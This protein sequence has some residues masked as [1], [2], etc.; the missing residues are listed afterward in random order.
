MISHLQCSLNPTRR[1]MLRRFALDVE[2]TSG[3]GFVLRDK[4]GHEYLDCLSQYGALPFGHNPPEIWAALAAAERDQVPA[5]V[6]PLR[7]AE[8]ERLAD[9]LAEITPG[10]LR[11]TTFTNSGAETVEAA[12]KLARMRS[13]R[14]RVLSTVNGFHGKTLGALSATGKAVY[15]NGFG[16][17]VNGFNYVPYGDLDALRSELAAGSEDIAAFIVE[18]IQGEGG[19]ICPPDGYID[20]VIALCREYGVLS[21]LDEIQ[22]GMGRTGSLFACS[23]GNETPDMLLLSKALGGG[24]IP[25]GACVVRPSAWDDRFGQLHSSTFAGN[26]LA[27]R[28][29][30][31][32]IDLLLRN[33][34]EM[35]RNVAETGAYL[36]DRLCALQAAYP[37]AIKE[38]R[39]RGYMLGLEFHRHDMRSESALMAFAS[40]NGG[41]TPLI[42]SYLLNQHKVLTAPLFNDT[43]V[44]RLQPPLVIS[45]TEVDRVIDALESLC[46]ALSSHDVYQLVRHLVAKP[47]A[48]N[49]HPLSQG[50]ALVSS[51]GTGPSESAKFAFLIHYTE[52]EDICR[53]DPSFE[54]FTDAELANWR[55]W[56]KQFGPGFARAI[57]RVRSKAG[58]SAEGWIVSVPMLPEDMQG[59][60]RKLASQM[61][62]DGVDLA[63]ANG[64]TRV[65]LG[66]F[67]SIVTRGGDMVTERGVPI[68]SG[69]TLTTISAVQGIEAMA[70]KSGIDIGSAH[71]VVVGASGAIGR[72]ASLM[73]ARQAGRLTLVGNP[74]NPFSPRLLSRVADEVC[75]TLSSHSG[76]VFARRGALQQRISSTARQL[77]LGSGDLKGLAERVRAVWR[78]Q[79][80][81]CPLEWNVPVEDALVDADIILVATSSVLSLVDPA[82]LRTGT[83]VCDVAK[84]RNVADNDTDGVLVFDGGLIKP[85]FE[86]DLGPFQTL[87]PNL[88]WGCLG[89]TM[90]LALAGEE[91][92]YS[93][94]SQ[95]SL[96]DADHLARLAALHGFE[97]APAQWCGKMLAEEKVLNFAAHVAEKNSVAS[98]KPMITMLH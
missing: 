97:P 80:I 60:G 75:E 22:T 14:S 4:E 92:D 49:I 20:G 1:E 89:E 11:I 37:T 65:G 50:P 13:G 79:G 61:V 7:S 18:P 12:I 16:A 36:R 3:T 76:N 9:R 41:I 72:L 85:P 34:Q 56:I 67:T 71:V 25:I 73:L 47:V 66:A 29:A 68:T 40:I 77:N 64:A 69:N 86:I 74:A 63:A 48:S 44:I 35:I 8:A 6:Q 33:D 91:R 81:G 51:A 94:G 84:P 70:H 27:C 96:A 53:S 93:I 23:N 59:E 24:L 57:P 5:M 28:A 58:A 39:G 46:M 38:V 83:L 54:Q 17:P 78:G 15:Q 90:L 26:S 52:E 2:M 21:I 88:C 10:D 87:L 31:A 19:V 98:I 42:S 95:L 55:D 62:R 43:H 45:R 32:T 82:Q 30:L